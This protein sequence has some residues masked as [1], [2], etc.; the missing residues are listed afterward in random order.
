MFLR[1]MVR[2]IALAATLG[3]TLGMASAAQAFDDTKYPDLSGQ[4]HRIGPDRFDGGTNR[5][6][7]LTPEYR[8]IFEKIRKNEAV[9]DAVFGPTHA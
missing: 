9:K 6:V 5:D 1:K 7:P 2:I 4:W 8:A 3:M